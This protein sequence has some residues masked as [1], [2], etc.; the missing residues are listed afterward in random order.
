MGYS[1]NAEDSFIIQYYKDKVGGKFIDVGAYDVFRFSNTRCLYER[2]F[3]GIFV[4]PQHKNYE[5]IAKHYEGDEN[6]TVLNFAVG[7]PAGEII[8]YECDGDAVGTTDREHMEK[9]RNGGVKYTEIK[10]QQVG[11]DEFF[12]KY[13]RGTDM[14]SIDTEATNILVFR[15]IP[16]WVWEEISLLVIEHDE[17][18]EEIENKLSEF[19]F[20]TL[21]VNAE[22]ILLAKV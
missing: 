6:I 21:Y 14:L 12:N 18:Q 9:W 20:S 8:F 17:H 3:S 7:D 2:G 16:I 22:N 1:Q 13:G 10:V 5:A 15:A 19:G 4:E 11:V